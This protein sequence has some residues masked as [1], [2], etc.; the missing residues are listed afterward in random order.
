MDQA[1]VVIGR[2]RREE[3][4]DLLFELL[5]CRGGWEPGKP[6]IPNPGGGRDDLK[7]D[8]QKLIVSVRPRRGR[9]RAFVVHRVRFRIRTR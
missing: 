4:S 7:V 1:L 6:R 2:P 8:G 3:L 9:A 5:H